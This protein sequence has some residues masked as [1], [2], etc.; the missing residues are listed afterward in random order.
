VQEPASIR[1][2]KR[3]RELRLAC[4]WTQEKAAEACGIGYKLYQLYE[5]GI[6]KNPGLLTLEK[7]AKGFGLE[8]HELLSPAPLPRPHAGKLPVF[9]KAKSTGG[10]KR[11]K[12]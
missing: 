10:G 8:L 9:K 4:R 5:L 11:S 3:L 1:F 2:K 7:I 12:G 6:K